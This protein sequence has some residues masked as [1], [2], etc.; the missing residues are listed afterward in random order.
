MMASGDA[1][2]RTKRSLGRVSVLVR[3]RQITVT[4]HPEIAEALRR[5]RASTSVITKAQTLLAVRKGKTSS[6]F[7]AGTR[8]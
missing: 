8:Q 5:R 2:F 1:I 4:G 7:G 3:F 6:D